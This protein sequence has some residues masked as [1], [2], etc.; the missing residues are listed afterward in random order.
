LHEPAQAHRGAQ[1]ESFRFL[2]ARD[3]ESLAEIGFGFI[4]RRAAADLQDQDAATAV[5]FRFIE[6]RAAF[7]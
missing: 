1:F 2:I 6:V 7:A 3:F 4:L 5:Q